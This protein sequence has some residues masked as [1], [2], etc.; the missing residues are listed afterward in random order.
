MKKL[1]VRIGQ[2]FEVGAFCVAVLTAS[3]SCGHDGP[4]HE[5]ITASAAALSDGLSA[6]LRRSQPA[7]RLRLYVLDA[8]GSSVIVALC[9]ALCEWSIRA[10]FTT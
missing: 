2:G 5:K 7:D 1:I 3:S 6:F 4:V 10:R 8:G 9:R